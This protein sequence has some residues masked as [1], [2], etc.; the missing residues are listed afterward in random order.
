MKSDVKRTHCDYALA[1]VV[2]GSSSRGTRIGRSRLSWVN[3]ALAAAS[4]RPLENA[5]MKLDL[6]NYSLPD[7]PPGSEASGVILQGLSPAEWDTFLGFAERL[8]FVAGTRIFSAGE[9]GRAIYIV[10]SGRVRGEVQLARRSGATSMMGPGAVFGELGFFDGAPRSASL[11]AEDD[12][13]LLVLPF[14]AFDTLAAWH[15]RIARELL[16]DLGRVLS[17]RLRRA[18]ARG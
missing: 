4:L 9:S 1:F 12:V 10:R 7:K 18:E 13:E 5:L 11:W 15:P 3:G 6:F 8:L 16:L 17:A 2:A 14:A